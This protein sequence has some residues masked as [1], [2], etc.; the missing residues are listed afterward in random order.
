MRSDAGVRISDGEVGGT[1]FLASCYLE[2]APASGIVKLSITADCLTGV[3]LFDSAVL[4]LREK[5]KKMRKEG[6]GDRARVLC[7]KEG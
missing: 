3:A 4:C 2:A 1:V 7:G 6:T 5:G